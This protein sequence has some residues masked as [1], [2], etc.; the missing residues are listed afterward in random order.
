[1]PSC[2]QSRV[3]NAP[4]EKVW[5]TI[6]CFHKLEWAPNVITSCEKVGT[7]TGDE[8]GAQRVL[9]GAFEE[10]LVSIEKDSFSFTYSIDEGVS[11]VS[12]K[13]VSNYIGVVSLKEI[14][15]TNETFIEWESSWKANVR[16]AEKFCHVLY[17]QMMADL[18]DH[19]SH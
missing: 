19:L 8:I 11:P 2:Y 5:G 10:T 16:D 3:I 12:S 14:T 9:N 7:I 17:V 4:I 6:K 18:N 15:Q 1:M 13:E